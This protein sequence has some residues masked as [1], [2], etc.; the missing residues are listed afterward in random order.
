[1]AAEHSWLTTTSK[2]MMFLLSVH[3]R[4]NLPRSRAK[5]TVMCR[6]S[7]CVVVSVCPDL[8]HT[9]REECVFLP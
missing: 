1:M 5:A 4:A 6:H 7:T 2:D 9:Q 3:S 8:G